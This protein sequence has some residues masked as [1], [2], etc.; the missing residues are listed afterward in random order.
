MNSVLA[1]AKSVVA[2]IGTVVTL[3]QAAAADQA[4]SLDEASGIWT[5]L[6]ALATVVGVYAVPNRP[7]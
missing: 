5:A 7:S 3:V 2:A 4:I 1:Y 6:L